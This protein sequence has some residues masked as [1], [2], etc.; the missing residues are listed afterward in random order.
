MKNDEQLWQEAMDSVV[1]KDYKATQESAV[2]EIRNRTIKTVGEMMEMGTTPEAIYNFVVDSSRIMDLLG[3]VT[4]EDL[5]DI[6]LTEEE[7]EL[8][9]VELST[10]EKVGDNAQLAAEVAKEKFN[11]FMES[12]RTQD[13]IENAK[14][15]GMTARIKFEQKMKELR[16]AEAKK[17]NDSGE[18]E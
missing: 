5:V 16:E 9:N 7:K 15:W 1:A 4:P 10:W 6:E 3:E 11:E 14:L 18:D 17:K 8:G 12:E 13:T 2:D